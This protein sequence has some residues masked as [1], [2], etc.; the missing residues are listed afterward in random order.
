MCVSSTESDIKPAE[1]IV[2][3]RLP[4]RNRRASISLELNPLRPT[5]IEEIRNNN[6]HIINANNGN[7]IREDK[8]SEGKG[9]EEGGSETNEMGT[10]SVDLEAGHRQQSVYQS[11]RGTTRSSNRI[12][13]QKRAT[14]MDVATGAIS[15]KSFVKQ[16]TRKSQRLGFLERNEQNNIMKMEKVTFLWRVSYC[17]CVIYFLHFLSLIGVAARYLLYLNVCFIAISCCFMLLCAGPPA[18]SEVI[19]KQK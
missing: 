4:S 3:R 6:K 10:N 11:R 8:I 2:A 18:S 15:F 1:Q 19:I 7:N 17:P 13:R 5:S 12:V 9:E 14:F 16:K